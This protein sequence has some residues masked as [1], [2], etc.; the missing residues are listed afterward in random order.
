MTLSKNVIRANYMSITV[1]MTFL[2]NVIPCTSRMT[3]GSH[4]IMSY[5]VSQHDIS[6]ECHTMLT[7]EDKFKESHT[8]HRQH[9]IIKEC[10]SFP[11]FSM[12]LLKNVIPCYVFVMPKC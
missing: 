2:E 3:Y 9:D 7:L 10:H 4:D 8:F 5:R 1:G 11:C 6:R 12:T